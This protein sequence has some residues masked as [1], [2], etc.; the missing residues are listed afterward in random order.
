VK[1]VRALTQTTVPSPRS[2]DGGALVRP[3]VSVVLPT[4]NRPVWLA[5][6]LTS[7]LN[8]ELDDVEVVVSNNG[9]P[10]HSRALQAAITD[11]RVRWLEQDPSLEPVDNFLAALAVARGKYVAPLHDDDRWS[12]KFLAALVPPLERHP[13]AVLAFADHYLVN[14]RGGIELAATQ[15]NSKRW[16]RAELPDGLHRPFFGVVA[17]QSVAITG[18]VFRRDALAIEDFPPDIGPFSD[19]WTSYLL[20]RSGGAA[21]YSSERLLF[22]RAH[23][24]SESSAARLSAHLAAIRGRRRMLGDPNFRPYRRLIVTRLARDHVLVGGELLRRGVR[25]DARVHLAAA[26]RLDPTLKALGGWTASWI[27]PREVLRRL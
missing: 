18:C 4:H 3:M 20:A 2:D 16:G 21:Y 12:P 14:A 23:D 13:E 22:Y 25:R 27:A 26:I 8:G 15:A 6:A 7:V 24:A 1:A 17:R 9:N 19:I 11:P 10:E 5:E